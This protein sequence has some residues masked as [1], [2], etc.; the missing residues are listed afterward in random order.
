MIE[1]ARERRAA[2]A[3]AATGRPGRGPIGPARLPCDKAPAVRGW[4]HAA[5]TDPALIAAWWRARPYNI[6]VA[7]G[8]SQLLVVDLDTAR[9]TTPPQQWAAARGGDVL[10]M[11]A[12][13]AG[14]PYPGHTFTVTTPSGGRHL[15]FRMPAGAA[16]RNTVGR[17]G[18]KIDTRGHGRIRRRRRLHPPRLPL[19]HH[20]QTRDRA[21]PGLAHRRPDHRA[22]LLRAGGAADIPAGQPPQIPARH[23]RPGS[24][25]SRRRPT[26]NPAHHTARRSVLPRPP[27][28]RRRTR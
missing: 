28:R 5:T 13:D 19:P 24:R 21:T 26:R 22:T 4:E 9:D 2:G 1:W 6:G 10:R 12:A 11:L 27:R 23:H 17:L 15:Y 14:Q 7:T 16:L 20:P 3:A 8:P 18:W 25:R